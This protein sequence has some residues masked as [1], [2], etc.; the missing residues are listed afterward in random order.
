MPNMVLQVQPVAL[1]GVRQAS[2]GS[3]TELEVLIHW[4]HLP[5]HE[6]SWENFDHI[7]ATFLDFHH[8]D[9]VHLWARGIDGPL[10]LHYVSLK[11]GGGP[12][13]VEVMW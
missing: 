6:D 5:D 7:N 13:A 8:A 4:E 10:D 1:Q 3:T 2:R 9:K 12:K 11:L